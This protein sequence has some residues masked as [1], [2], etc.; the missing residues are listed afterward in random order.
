LIPDAW[1][2]EVAIAR[3]AGPSLE[4]RTEEIGDDELGIEWEWE[5]SP[6]V[7]LTVVEDVD[8]AIDLFNAQ[9]PRFVASL[10]S[11]SPDAHQSFWNRIDA[12]FVGNGFTRW[13]DGQY[14]LTDPNWAC[15]TGS[16]VACSAGEGSCRAIPCTRSAHE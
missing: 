9:S 2:E 1:F 16:S 3:A 4:P 10:I 5:R 15:P 7:T 6:E 14:A 8:Q 12:P 11:E 13:V